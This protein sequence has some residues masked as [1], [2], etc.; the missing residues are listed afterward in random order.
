MTDY[1]WLIPLL[2]LAGSAINGL[3]G[4]RLPKAADLR[5]RL[6]SR[7]ALV[8]PRTYLHSSSC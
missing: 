7:R 5:G 2:P 1:L 8:H 6:R 4:K 3:A